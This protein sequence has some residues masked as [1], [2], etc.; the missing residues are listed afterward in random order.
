MTVL[1]QVLSDWSFKSVAA[2]E[3]LPA[4]VPGTVHTDLFK[5]NTIPDP[6][7]GTHE[8]EL[9]WI[10]KED[11]EYQTTFDLSEHTF[12]SS[13]LELVFEGLDT[14]A[15]VYLN[16]EKILVADN[17]FRTWRVDI[18]SRVRQMENTLRIY[19]Y[20]PV[21]VDL[22][23]LDKLGY[24]LPAPNDQSDRGGLGDKKISVFARK[25]PYH[26]G[27]DWGPRFVTSGIWRDVYIEGWSGY[28]I[29]DLFIEQL[30]VTPARAKLN[31]IVEVEADTEG[32]VELELTV[33][34][35]AVREPGFLGTGKNTLQ[36]GI[37][38]ENPDLWW[39]RGLGEPRQYQFVAAVMK[40]TDL[41]AQ[42][43]VETGLRSVRLVREPDEAGTSFYIELN[44][45]PVFAKGANHIPNDSFLTEVTLE[46]YQHE[47]LT[48]VESNMNLLR[49]WGGGIYENDEF[50]RLCDEHGILVWQDFM[51]ACS[52][53]PG[54]DAFLQSVQAEVIDNVKRLRNHPCIALW[55]GNNEIDTAWS[56]Y[57]EEAGWGWKQHYS[58]EQRTKLWGDYEA[59]F[60]RLLPQTLAQLAPG[61]AYWPSS[62]L[63]QLT[64]DAHQHA[65]NDSVSRGDVHYWGVWHAVEPF[66][67]YAHYVGRFMSEYGFQSFPEMKTVRSYAGSEDL[68]LQSEVMRWHQ[69]SGDGNR[70][71]QEYMDIYQREPKDFASFLYMSQVLQAEAIQ[72]AIAAHRRNKPFCMGTLY[73]QI[74]DCWPVASWS[75]MDYYGR[76]KALQ[77]VVKRSYRDIAVLVG[78]SGAAVQVDVVSDVLDG[79]EGTVRLKL[80]DFSG[81]VR[82]ERLY[83]FTVQGNSRTQIVELEQA[84]LLGNL[85]PRQA[86][87]EVT[88]EAGSQVLDS[89]PFYFAPTKEL[90]LD[91]PVITVQERM[92]E[93]GATLVLETTAFA[94]SVW[95]SAETEGVFSDNLFDLVPGTKKTVSFRP[96]HATKEFPG[97]VQ[98]VGLQVRSMV[99]FV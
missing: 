48:A 4:K 6:F 79:I 14:Y 74:N 13:H 71:I 59:I 66:S 19:F 8:R 30:Q 57:D 31:A 93:R 43:K 39:A 62:P 77:Y 9:Q 82:L 73:W 88:L 75:S 69:R 83:P 5:N 51:F 85:N 27:W 46:R 10:D 29:T 40:G 25:A 64:G 63:Q 21:Q 7:V 35:L 44:G 37:E 52:M 45:V 84:N 80:Y 54:D 70:L 94:K 99:D 72:M 97:A 41:L 55:C 81:K 98:I 26:Y 96:G 24:G 42:S 50:Y 18:K 53:Y 33:E 95:L 15:D 38:M 22:S 56:N 34:K 68:D 58:T 86:V 78:Q 76:W 87:L 17:M 16:D 90:L 92:E 2:N 67:N 36:L 28:R 89:K 60:H 91:K 65:S 11:W 61:A 3:W 47:I 49:V 32:T 12:A 1:K 20:S 23:K